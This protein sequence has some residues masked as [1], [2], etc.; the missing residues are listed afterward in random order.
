MKKFFLRIAVLLIAMLLSSCTSKSEVVEETSIDTTTV[1]TKST[2]IE[3]IDEVEIMELVVVN[4]ADT[5][6]EETEFVEETTIPEEVELPWETTIIYTNA[7]CNLRSSPG[8]E[9]N[10][11]IAVLSE[12]TAIEH[13]LGK[14]T[15]DWY[16]VIY[17]DFRGY[18][19]E[20]CI[21]AP[22]IRDVTYT[23]EERTQYELQMGVTILDVNLR[24]APSLESR[25]KT[26]IK[27]GTE[28]ILFE[29]GKDWS[30]VQVGNEMG[31]IATGY[32]KKQYQKRT[33]DVSTLK[34]LTEFKTYYTTYAT[35][36]NRNY[37]IAKACELLNGTSLKTNEEISFND[38]C[39][40]PSVSGEYKESTIMINGS[41][42]DPVTGERYT[43]YGG[44]I[45]QVCSTLH[46]AFKSIEMTILE[47]HP[48]SSGVGYIS[49]E[50]EATT[51]YPYYDLRVK[52]PYKDTLTI[53][54]TAV[55]GVC[56]ISIYSDLIEQ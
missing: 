48:H 52:N 7:R 28:I 50:L 55:N 56:T 32:F 15:E 22:Y 39:N 37:N 12:D 41:I 10:N 53:V 34:L 40:N 16:F 24:E 1:A 29:R 54:A 25:I 19:H 27:Q 31:Y 6:S 43:D 30:K 26:L 2:P 13:V 20:S 46:A 44:G 11:V 42:V 47:R 9:E 3:N 23:D 17:E 36:E 21:G 35:D 18:I 33:L 45:C 4:V 8:I 5:T 38:L 51:A 14:G 49:R